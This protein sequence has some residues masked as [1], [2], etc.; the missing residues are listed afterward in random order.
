M[1]HA[2]RTSNKESV[3]DRLLL[4]INRFSIDK[5]YEHINDRN[6]TGGR[7][8]TIRNRTTC[9]TG[10]RT[11]LCKI[12]AQGGQ[13]E[14]DTSG[15]PGSLSCAPSRPAPV[16]APIHPRLSTPPLHTARGRCGA[17][18]VLPCC[19]AVQSPAGATA[20]AAAA[21]AAALSAGRSRSGPIRDPLRMNESGAACLNCAPCR[22]LDSAP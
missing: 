20:A 7:N 2:D 5:N 17:A 15:L 18:L 4:H 13:H 16:D 11:T 22:A 3:S 9:A 6:R 1:R 14:C 10:T 21:A 19:A 8:R 12:T